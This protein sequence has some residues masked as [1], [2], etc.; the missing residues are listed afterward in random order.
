MALVKYTGVCG[1]RT[2]EGRTR[3]T[4][5]GVA[6]RVAAS[7]CFMQSRVGDVRKAIWS[8]C[9]QAI[10]RTMAQF[11]ETRVLHSKRLALLRIP[12]PS[13]C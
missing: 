3:N 10:I 6:A 9:S 13:S 7:L 1:D 11:V 5:S 8:D 12:E 4:I 2:P